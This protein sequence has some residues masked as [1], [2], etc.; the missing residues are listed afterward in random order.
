MTD[1][2]FA[3]SRAPARPGWR[4]WVRRVAM[5]AL[6]WAILTGGEA[7][8]WLIGAPVIVFAAWVSLTV[9]AVAPL[10][11][12]G[13][14]RF[15]P[16]FAWQ[17]VAGAS[18][19]AIRAFRPRMPL[20]PGLVR[21]RVRLPPGASRVALA[22]VISMLPGTLSADLDG[23]EVLVHALDTS[24]DVHEMILDLEPRVAAVFGLSLDR[25]GATGD[26]R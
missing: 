14:A 9:W 12:R 4:H 22:N 7:G 17:S 19:V 23:E 21:H 6:L 11:L 26:A 16:W 25:A 2:S 20:Q 3:A 5:F 1:S 24:H 18:D 10:S 13:L 15:L 8:S